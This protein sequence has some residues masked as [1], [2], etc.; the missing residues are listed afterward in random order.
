MDPRGELALHW[1]ESWA[2]SILLR[3]ITPMRKLPDERKLRSPSRA[4]GSAA[5]THTGLRWVVLALGSACVSALLHCQRGYPLPPTACDDWCLVTQRAGCSE[6]DPAGCVSDCEDNAVGRRE[7]ECEG[8]WLRLSDCYRAAPADD[9]H[10]IQGES[11]P[12]AICVD[13]RV[14]LSSCVWPLAGRCLQSCLREKS[15][16]EQPQRDC[17]EECQR[18]SP[19]CEDSE[20]S[21]YDCRLASTVDCGETGSEPR[22]LEDIPCSGEALTWLA[23]VG[24]DAAE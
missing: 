7:P 11:Q 17:E 18:S 1:T 6:D 4:C 5:D 23:C 3:V 10:C 2:H 16:C 12:G 24:F 19:E 21:L 22:A 8:P 14:E 13:Q 9:F 20:R 15:E